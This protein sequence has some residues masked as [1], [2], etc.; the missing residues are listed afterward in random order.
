MECVNAIVCVSVHVK[1]TCIWLWVRECVHVC[2]HV[3]AC[4]SEYVL[5]YVSVCTYVEKR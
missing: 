3:Y 5:E 2:D 4:D 1:C